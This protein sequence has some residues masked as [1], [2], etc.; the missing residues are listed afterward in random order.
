MPDI[1]LGEGKEGRVYRKGDEVV[2]VFHG[3][4]ISDDAGRRLVDL[5]AGFGD[6]FPDGVTM[7][8]EGGAW[9]VRY[10]WFES[11]PVNGVS[12]KELVEYLVKAGGLRV[13]ADNFKLS[14]LRRRA[15]RLVYIDVGRHIRAFNRS[16]FRDVCAKAFALFQ[17][18]SEEQLVSEF[19]GLRQSGGV[20]RIPGFASFYTEVVG[21]VASSFWAACPRPTAAA[22]GGDVTLLIKCCAMDSAYLERQVG[23][24]VHRLSY[25]RGFKEIVLS[26]DPKVGSF[27]RQHSS[28]DLESLR[29]AARRLLVQGVIDR[30]VESRGGVD[31]IV[32]VNLRWFGVPSAQTHTASGIPV[33]PQIWAFEQIGTRYV[34]QA[35]C[36]VLICRD[37]FTHDYLSEMLAAHAEDGV[38]GIGFNIPQRP[39]SSARAYAAPVGEFKPE[40]RLGLFDLMRLRAALPLPNRLSGAHLEYG[41]YQALHRALSLNGWR[42]LRGGD[43]RTTYIHPLNTAKRLPGFLDRVRRCVES[44]RVPD[45]QH[46]KWDLVENPGDWTASL[47]RHK[48]F[49]ALAAT[50]SDSSK[51]TRCASSIAGQDNQDFGVVVID[52]A[53]APAGVAELIALLNIYGVQAQVIP[54]LD[55]L[56]ELHDNA[57]HVLLLASDE[58]LMS[59][60]AIAQL[61]MLV[62]ESNAGQAGC[63]CDSAGLR[64]SPRFGLAAM[65]VG[66][67][68]ERQCLSPR[69]FVASSG[70][71]VLPDV[72]GRY[73]SC[74]TLDVFAETPAHGGNRR[75][76]VMAGFVVWNERGCGR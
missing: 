13:I 33:Y 51:V 35:D 11:E 48:L 4:V 61:K 27:L 42:C 8:K 28:G 45:A 75:P 9:V 2:K 40:V 66:E 56:V 21:R 12:K 55:G 53:T 74:V 19:D 26:I 20:E 22:V 67:V 76:P 54:S 38:M 47:P 3:G 15:G 60:S 32:A 18:M 49:V 58:A 6:P 39:S 59:P 14:N 23:H 1:L 52:D 36:D 31:E 70:V 37:D 62:D 17:G 46:G 68:A 73:P 5:V 69:C 7:G 44:G 57:P 24:I 41:W 10:P 64:K 29:I 71:V 16:T 72:R 65:Y 50:H 34:L 63:L 25:P 30:V 43:P